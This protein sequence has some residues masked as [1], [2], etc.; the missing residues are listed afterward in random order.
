VTKG[1]PLATGLACLLVAAGCLL[2]WLHLDADPHY[3]GWVGHLYDEGRWVQHARSLALGHGLFENGASPNLMVAPGFELASYAS[4]WIGGVGRIAAHAF[5]AI[6]GCA[7]LLLLFAYLRPRTS[8]SGLALGV[9]LIALQSD[10]VV[11]SRV[12]VP[13]MTAMLGS[14]VA[15]AALTSSP[16]TSRRLMLAGF[17]TAVTVALKVTTLSLVAV[18]GVVA[19]L[20]R[21]D[22]GARRRFSD[23]LRFAAGVALAVSPAI[24]LA[25]WWAASNTP[26]VQAWMP[27]LARFVGVN[28]PYAMIALP[29]DSPLAPVLDTASLALWA[30][31]LA[32]IGGPTGDPA[33]RRAARGAMLWAVL[34]LGVTSAQV[35]AP[36][37]YFVHALIPLAVL[38]AFAATRLEALGATGV[39]R[40]IEGRRGLARAV[41]VAV[42]CLPIAVFLAPLVGALLGAAGAPVQRLSVRAPA[43]M[44]SWLVAGAAFAWIGPTPRSVGFVIAS[45]LVAASAW[46]CA[47]TLLDSAP[48]FWIESGFARQGV[49]RLGLLSLVA[50]VALAAASTLGTRDR[51][52][53]AAASLACIWSAAFWVDLAPGFVSP[54]Y[55]ARDAS[56]R[57]AEIVDVGELVLQDRAEGLF[58]DNALRYRWI[59]SPYTS[60][61][62]K[63]HWTQLPHRYLLAELPFRGDPKYLERH[64]E[65]VRIFALH[66]PA[67][68]WPR[69]PTSLVCA[70]AAVR[71]VALFRRKP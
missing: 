44:A 24:V 47:W 36:E 4:F 1:Q 40:G 56:V 16:P 37:R 55:S 22:A 35:Y 8:P 34:Y 6:C 43:L 51:R 42:L 17:L 66:A 45:T 25:L 59:W 62:R 65:R 27:S 39:A 20:A 3:Y 31:G 41:A 64:Y 5:P 50:G 60:R 71:C 48:A 58:L 13:E 7:L 32:W 46:I 26:D 10:A 67:T 21:E 57:L 2:R 68:R 9:G 19:F 15:F 53:W 38:A 29:F 30:A 28:R 61:S 11:L 63:R 23:L 54:R 49:M 52:A 12:A 18:F 69:S 33:L 14:L 70:D